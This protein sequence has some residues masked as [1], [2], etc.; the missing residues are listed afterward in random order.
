MPQR[1]PSSSAAL[2]VLADQYIF[3]LLSSLAESTKKGSGQIFRDFLGKTDSRPMPD[4]DRTS[5]CE[6]TRIHWL[7]SQEDH[8][9]E[10]KIEQAVRSMKI[11]QR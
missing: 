4:F 2:K 9:E 6:S 10:C 5:W 8:S 1:L 11:V 3:S 7:K